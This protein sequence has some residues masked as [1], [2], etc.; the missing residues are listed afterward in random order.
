[1]DLRCP[2]CESTNLK[3]ISLAYQEGTYHINSRTRIRGLLFAGGG[4]GALVGGATTRGSQQSALSKRLSPPSKWSYA[5]LVLWSGVVTLMAL[6][7][8]VQHVMSSP[9]P[10]SSLPVKLY[11]VFAPVVLFL[12]LGIV[13]R[14]NHSTYRQKYAEWDESFICE[15]CGTV[16]QQPSVKT[17]RIPRF[18]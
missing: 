17:V 4:P 12:L 9:V 3:K 6:V 11:V 7:L 14:H 15:R 1:M 18:A 13:W 5:K 10:A 8:Y 2:N 16:C